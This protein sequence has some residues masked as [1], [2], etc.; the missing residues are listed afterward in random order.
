MADKKNKKTSN[1]KLYH[2]NYNKE[3][4]KKNKERPC[5]MLSNLRKL[6]KGVK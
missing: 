4:Y 5:Y 3:Y 1:L 6:A 2:Q